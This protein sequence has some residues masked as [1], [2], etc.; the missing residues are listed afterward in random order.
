MTLFSNHHHVRV[1]KKNETVENIMTFS[2]YGRGFD[3]LDGWLTIC[4]DQECYIIDSNATLTN[5]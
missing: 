1:C 5:G 2:I 4:F 3:D